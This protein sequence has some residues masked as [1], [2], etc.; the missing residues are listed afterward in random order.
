MGDVPIGGLARQRRRHVR[1]S[2]DLIEGLGSILAIQRLV[3]RHLLLDA[4]PEDGL[5]LAADLESV[6]GR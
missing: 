6:A 3:L 4:P 1:L 2:D 5:R